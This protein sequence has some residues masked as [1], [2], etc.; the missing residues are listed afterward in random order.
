MGYSTRVVAHTLKVCAKFTFDYPYPKAV[1]TF[2]NQGMEYPMIYWNY[3]S[4]TDGSYSDRTKYAMISVII[5]EVGHNFP[6]IVNSMKGNGDGWMRVRPFVQYLT[7]QEFE[8]LSFKRE[9]QKLLD[10][11]G[12]QILFQL[13]QIPV[14]F[15]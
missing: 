13:C 4:Q 12:D 5:H 10:M 3:R 11:S 6:M 14:Y 9:P 8:K 2:K 1:C 7:E 15:N